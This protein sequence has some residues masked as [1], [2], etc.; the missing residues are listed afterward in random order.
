METT[1]LDGIDILTITFVSSPIDFVLAHLSPLYLQ[2]SQ[3]RT[4][5]NALA[6]GCR[7]NHQATGS[8][9]FGARQNFKFLNSS[10][11]AF[12]QYIDGGAH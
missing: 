3:L 6:I 2:D 10:T 8:F 11:Y 12:L 7:K 5:E 1:A 4:N 9:G